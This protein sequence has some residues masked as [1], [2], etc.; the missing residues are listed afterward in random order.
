MLVISTFNPRRL[1]TTHRIPITTL[2]LITPRR[3]TLTTTSPGP[4]RS[5]GKTAPICRPR[6]G[7][8]WRMKWYNRRWPSRICCQSCCLCQLL[9]RRRLARELLVTH[10]GVVEKRGHDRCCLFQIITLNAIEHVLI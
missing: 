6:L 1:A 7:Y 10:G 5:S 4:P 2:L 9:R 3:L 8:A